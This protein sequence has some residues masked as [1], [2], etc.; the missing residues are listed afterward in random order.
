MVAPDPTPD[1]DPV[2]VVTDLTKVHRGRPPT[3]AVDRVSFALGRGEI[4]GLLGP[5]GAGKTTT[6]QMLLSVLKPTSGRI[7]YFGKPLDRARE[8]VLGRVGFA[9]GYSRLPLRLTVEENLDVFGRLYRLARHERKARIEEL[10]A[11]FGVLAL[12]RRLML[13][14]SAGETTRVMLAKAFLAMMLPFLFSLLMSGWF[15]GFTASGVII[16]YGQSVQSVAWMAGFALAPFSAVYY[17]VEVLLRWA[18]C[19]AAALPM[20]Y[21][22]EGTRAILRGEREPVSDLLIS[23]GLNILY[24]ALSVLLFGWMFEKSRERGLARLE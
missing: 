15:M 10:L 4:L 7:E 11:W 14:L 21:I 20:T 3:T 22:F 12:R 8:K 6:I 2:L 18:Q 1:S 5:N 13:G 9:S 19:I 17:P 16:R 24:L 23:F